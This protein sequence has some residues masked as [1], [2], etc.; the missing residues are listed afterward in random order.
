MG[1]KMNLHKYTNFTIYGYQN[2]FMQ[3][4]LNII[5]NAKDALLNNAIGDRNITIDI[6]K[7]L[8]YIIIDISDNG[9]GIDKKSI[10]KIF[11]QYF[12]TKEK[13]HGIGLYMTKLIIEDKLNGK[14]S[15][16]QKEKGSCFRITIKEYHENSRS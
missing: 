13:G 14:I 3:A 16:K 2:E 11:L 1:I 12:S 8:S 6:Y 15:Y 4:L 10:D 9:D 5:N 7:K